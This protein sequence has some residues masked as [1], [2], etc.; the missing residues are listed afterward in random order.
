MLAG[1]KEKDEKKG[2][3]CLPR[4][5]LLL[6]YVSKVK[7]K[8]S[9]R[10]PSFVNSFCQI[11]VFVHFLTLWHRKTDEDEAALGYAKRNLWISFVIPLV[12]TTL[13]F[14]RGFFA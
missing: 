3:E 5:H 14:G 2:A 7:E 12:C 10:R 1:C 11:A 8:N 13:T 6:F 9:F 4:I